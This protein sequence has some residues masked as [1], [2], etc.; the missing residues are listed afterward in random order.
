MELK[1]KQK[2]VYEVEYDDL[3]EFIK[4][5]YGVKEFYFTDDQELANYTSKT[6]NVS[7]KQPGAYD[8]KKLEKFM[9]GEYVQ[10]MTQTLLNNLC[11]SGLLEAG[12]YLVKVFW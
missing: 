6:F 5:H 7:P 1:A 12:E 10:F 3:N 8:M 2:I 11:F 9:A 4:Y